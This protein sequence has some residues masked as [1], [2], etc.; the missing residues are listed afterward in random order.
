[1]SSQSFPAPKNKDS[2]FQH[3]AKKTINNKFNTSKVNDAKFNDN[4]KFI[5]SDSYKSFGG[6]Q[7][8]TYVNQYNK[9]YEQKSYANEDFT[10]LNERE[11]IDLNA[12]IN[13]CIKNADE[14]KIKISKEIDEIINNKDASKTTINAVVEVQKDK[15]IDICN[16]I[17]SPKFKKTVENWMMFCKAI[18]YQKGM[19]DLV[20]YGLTK[21]GRPLVEEKISIIHNNWP[22]NYG[23]DSF[24]LENLQVCEKKCYTDL[25]N[26]CQNFNVLVYDNR[27]LPS[28]NLNN[29]LYF[30]NKTQTYNKSLYAEIEALEK[31][32]D[33]ILVSI[34]A[35]KNEDEKLK[36]NHSLDLVN[37]KLHPFIKRRNKLDIYTKY[38]SGMSTDK[39]PLDIKDDGG[40]TLD[41]DI[42]K[43]SLIEIKKA[44]KAKSRLEE[45][46]KIAIAKAQEMQKLQ[47]AQDREDAKK[48]YNAR[49]SSNLGPYSQGLSS[50]LSPK[51]NNNNVK[52]SYATAVASEFV[53]PMM[54]KKDYEERQRNDSPKTVL[55]PPSPTSSVART[56]IS[57][58]MSS[59]RKSPSTLRSTS[60][61]SWADLDSDSDEEEDE[62]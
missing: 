4:K 58:P 9:N 48:Q 54:T 51:F 21:E 32:K 1:M 3:F 62:E 30:F 18:D 46:A 50:L 16:E 10:Y 27:M 14:T 61:I 17:L 35:A 25:I 7:Q 57:S 31:E 38:Q 56:S 39:D 43:N 45:S 22:Y 40:K 52:T 29:R 44:L 23:K 26:T 24:L 11:I 53:I 49:T 6:K 15:I 34:K 42:F 13:T 20:T 41:S 19:V 12:F 28:K 60:V 5:Q 2:T 59:N 47:E 36:L 37:K 8:N 33:E 55:V